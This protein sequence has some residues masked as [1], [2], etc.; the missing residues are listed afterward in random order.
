MA[1]REDL[2]KMSEE[3][4]DELVHETKSAEA[5]AINNAGKEAQIEYI[6]YGIGV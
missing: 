5:A 1:S 4:R 2:E 6:L 3:D